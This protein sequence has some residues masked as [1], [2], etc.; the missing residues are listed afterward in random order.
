LRRKFPNT[1]SVVTAHGSCPTTPTASTAGTTPS[2]QTSTTQ[3]LLLPSPGTATEQSTTAA[4]KR[5]IAA[6]E[7]GRKMRTENREA[8]ERERANIAQ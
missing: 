4:V 3:G 8:R 2:A 6:L 1:T 5:K 7:G